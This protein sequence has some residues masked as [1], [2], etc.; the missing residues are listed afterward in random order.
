MFPW[1]AE[2]PAVPLALLAGWF[3]DPNKVVLQEAILAQAPLVVLELGS[4]LGLSTRFLCVATAADATVIAVD[5]WLG[6]EEHAH[7]PEAAKFLP[8]LHETFIANCWFWQHKLVP[9]RLSVEEAIPLLLQLGICPGVIYVDAAHDEASVERHVS[10][11]I[12]AFPN[13]RIV[14][15]DWTFATV[16]AGVAKALGRYERY[17]LTTYGVCYAICRRELLA[18]E[19]PRCNTQLRRI[20]AEL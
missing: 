13:A 12:E 19:V 20:A 3:C 14:G 17:A 6:S 15:D 10:L 11:C 2:R 5:H 1:P 18:T 7:M 9:V 8:V 4:W 16:R